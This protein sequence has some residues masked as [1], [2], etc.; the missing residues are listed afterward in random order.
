[1]CCLCSYKRN[2][3]QLHFPENLS[4][5]SSTSPQP[6]HLR[7]D[8]TSEYSIKTVE[9]GSTNVERSYGLA[10]AGGPSMK[11][12]ST[13]S[14]DPSNPPNSPITTPRSIAYG[15]GLSLTS[16]RN[17][18]EFDVGVPPVPNPSV[19]Y[20]AYSDRFSSVS[21]RRVPA[22]LPPHSSN[23]PAYTRTGLPSYPSSYP[24]NFY[25]PQYPHGRYLQHPGEQ[26]PLDNISESTLSL[27][28]FNPE[29][30]A[31]STSYTVTSFFDQEGD[32]V[33]PHP[34]HTYQYDEAPP[35]SPVT[36][37]CSEAIGHDE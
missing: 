33:E 30:V 35:P 11:R 31:D 36:E 26:D 27:S 20:D 18:S 21:Q 32:T 16:S 15:D 19:N 34:D 28:T 37:Y 22:A 12:P 9:T 6:S 5:Q 23:I 3:K 1:M 2:N 29:L 25:S 24:Y 14:T 17:F 4:F 10:G 8:V 7:S 13:Y